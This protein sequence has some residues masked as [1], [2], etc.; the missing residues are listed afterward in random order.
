MGPQA[1]I[2]GGCARIA[3]GAVGEWVA[4]QH[5]TPPLTLPGPP[6]ADSRDHLLCVRLPTRDDVSSRLREASQKV[7]G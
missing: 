3:G 5:Q 4:R 1:A 2:T 6:S 7:E